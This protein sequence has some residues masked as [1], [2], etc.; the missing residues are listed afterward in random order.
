MWRKKAYIL[1]VLVALCIIL[2]V[3]QPYNMF[4]L[5][6]W[7]DCVRVNDRTYYSIGERKEVDASSIEDKVGTVT[8]KV[9]QNIHNP[10]YHLKNGDAT[11]L[12]VGTELY[13][14]TSSPGSIAVWMNGKY[15]VFAGR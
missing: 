9:S 15:Y 4:T 1:A 2:P 8:F 10:Q 14:M 13:S 11:Y 5:V 3:Y 6:D 7:V 12:E